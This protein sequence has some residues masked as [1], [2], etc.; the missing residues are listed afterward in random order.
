M[1]KHYPR[2]FRLYIESADHE[3][4]P[5]E[6]GATLGELQERLSTYPPTVRAFFSDAVEEQPWRFLGWYRIR[7]VRTISLKEMGL[8]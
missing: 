1:F 5:L 4:H 6:E 7:I 2:R 3:R 8:R